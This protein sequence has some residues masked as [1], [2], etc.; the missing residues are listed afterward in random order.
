MLCS[1]RPF[2]Y[3][4]FKSM[5]A[6]F[7]S[8]LVLLICCSGVLAQKTATAPSANKLD[9]YMEAGMEVADVEMPYY[10]DKGELQAYLYGGYVKV[11]EG[12]VANVTNLRIDVHQ[13]DEVIMTIFAPQCFTKLNDSTENEFLEVYS[14]GDVLIDMTQMTIIGRGFKFSSDENKFEI[15]NDSKVLVRESARDMKGVEL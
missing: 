15:Q 8:L 5:K 3:Y 7:K 2:V 6:V 9:Q 4:D 13:D 10:N 12:Q 14:E 11:L 1:L